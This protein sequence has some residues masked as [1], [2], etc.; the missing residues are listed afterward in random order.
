VLPLWTADRVRQTFF[1]FF[2]QRSHVFVSG[3]SVVPQNDPTLLFTNAGMNQFKPVFL[4]DVDAERELG[5]RRAVNVQK[6]IRA[7]GK[8][9]GAYVYGDAV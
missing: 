5:T 7:G 1:E 3:S 8:H 9:N 2:Q 6:C 4:G